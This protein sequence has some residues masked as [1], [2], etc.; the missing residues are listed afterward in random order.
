MFLESPAMSDLS[1]TSLVKTEQEREKN[2]AEK[3]Q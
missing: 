1:S 2:N 3:N